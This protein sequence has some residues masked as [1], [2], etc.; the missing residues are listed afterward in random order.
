MDHLVHK[1]IYPMSDRG[2]LVLLQ[3][4]APSN[5]HAIRTTQRVDEA[6]VAF[7]GWTLATSPPYHAQLPT[8]SYPDFE[9]SRSNMALETLP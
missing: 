2:T 8:S 5:T 9:V 3:V 7:A 6:V 4:N 1:V